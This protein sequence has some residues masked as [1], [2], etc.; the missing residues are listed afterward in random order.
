LTPEYEKAAG[1]GGGIVLADILGV[2]VFSGGYVLISSRLFDRLQVVSYLSLLPVFVLVLV[3][4]VLGLLDWR[5]ARKASC[6]PSRMTVVATV[7]NSISV[8]IWILLGVV[9]AMIITF[10]PPMM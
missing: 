10:F 3:G 8:A 5:K 9:V 4:F 2:I 6:R 1:A 7:L